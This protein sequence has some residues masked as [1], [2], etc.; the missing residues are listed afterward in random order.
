MRYLDDIKIQDE[1]RK[2]DIVATSIPIANQFCLNVS[3]RDLI[4]GSGDASTDTEVKTVDKGKKQP[5][6]VQ[7]P[8]AVLEEYAIVIEG[9]L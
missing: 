8:S 7:P 6:L 9:Y 3:I 1:D 4:I 2:K 5:N